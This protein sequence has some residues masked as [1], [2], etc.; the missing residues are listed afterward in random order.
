MSHR[1]I[2]QDPNQKGH[3]ILPHYAFCTRIQGLV[4]PPSSH[5]SKAKKNQAPVQKAIANKKELCQLQPAFAF[6]LHRLLHS[7]STPQVEEAAV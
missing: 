4:L 1:H 2:S 5:Q 3:Q 6:G 7:S